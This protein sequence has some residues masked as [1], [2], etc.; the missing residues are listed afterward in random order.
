MIIRMLKNCLFL[1]LLIFLSVLSGQISQFYLSN[2]DLAVYAI[3]RWK[4]ENSE[5]SETAERF[6]KDCFNSPIVS[7]EKMELALFR[8]QKSIS[9]DDCGHAIDAGDLVL[10][11]DK[12]NQS[13]NSIA[14]P[15]S[16][17]FD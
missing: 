3:E 8:I 12:A 9:L 16:I 13:I 15:L 4:S 10:E 17:F 14:L 1:T 2:N 5:N 7:K 11:I 6:V